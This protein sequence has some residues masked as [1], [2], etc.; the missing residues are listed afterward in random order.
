MSWTIEAAL[1]DDNIESSETTNTG[2]SFW[3][4]GIPTEI[5]IVLSVNPLQ[6]GFNFQVSHSIHTPMQGSPHRPSRPWGD[7]EAY[8]LHMAVTSITQYYKE[9]VMAGRTPSPKWLVPN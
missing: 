6:G 7:D 3:L 8:A 9:A 5:Q 1:E 2:Y 4:K